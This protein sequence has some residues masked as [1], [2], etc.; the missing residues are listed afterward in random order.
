V[1]VV[2]TS[3]AAVTARASA[4]VSGN[5]SDAVS[6]S[7]VGSV[8]DTAGSSI[9]W[10]NFEGV[11]TNVAAESASKTQPEAEA[12]TAQVSPQELDSKVQLAL[13]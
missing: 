9:N 10:I 4:E 1:L 8:L 5:L 13:P 2:I 3:V 11:E 6:N 12:Q 7:V